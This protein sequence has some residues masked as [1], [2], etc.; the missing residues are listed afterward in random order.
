MANDISGLDGYLYW[1]KTPTDAPGAFSL[2]L[3]QTPTLDPFPVGQLTQATDYRGQ[4][5]VSAVDKAGNATAKVAFN[6]IEAQTLNPNPETTPMPAERVARI[7]AIVAKCL[8]AG[9][10]PGITLGIVSPYGYLIKSYGDGSTSKEKYFRMASQSKMMTARAVLR[11]IE[12]GLLSFE[13]TLEQ[14]IPGVPNGEM[15]TVEHML[16]MTSGIFDHQL[17]ASLGLNFTLN[18]TMAMSVDQMIDYIKTGAPMFVPGEGYYY[19][20]GNYFLLGRILEVLDPDQRSADQI[21]TEDVLIPV[22]MSNTYWQV[23]TGVPRSPYDIMYDNDPISST[24]IGL[25]WGLTL[26]LFGPAPVV[27]RDVSAQNPNFVWAAGAN[28]SL[29]TDMI[30][31]G[32]ELLD[33]TLLSTEMNELLTTHFNEHPTPPWGLQKQGPPRYK[34]GY[35]LYRIEEWIGHGGSWLGADSGTMVHPDTGTIITVFNNFQ[36]PTAPAMTT[37]FF[38]IATDLLPGSTAMAPTVVRPESGSIGYSGGTPNVNVVSTGT[39]IPTPGTITFTGGQPTIV[40]PV[41]PAAGSIGF[42]GG[43]PNVNVVPTFE[44]V[45][46]FNQN[47]TDEPIPAGATVLRILK[48]RG[49]G[50]NGSA[51]TAVYNSTGG[52]GGGSGAVVNEITIPVADLDASVYSTKWG[53]NGGDS[54]LICGGKRLTAKGGKPGTLTT[55]YNA[56]VAGGLGGL[57]EAVG[58]S[59]ATG[60]NGKKGGDSHMN[61]GGPGVSGAG[62]DVGGSGAGGRGSWGGIS[63]GVQPGGSS[64]TVTGTTGAG[65]DAAGDGAGAGGGEGEAGGDWGAGGGGGYSYGNVGGGAGGAGAPGLIHLRWE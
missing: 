36:W 23:D 54:E 58:V 64:L 20:N 3:N 33:G 4:Y 22:G 27:K 10:G 43:T 16:T 29:I 9:A 52:S 48:I 5:A 62:V 1:K 17:A 26:G 53:V 15:I 41:V 31:W 47:L 30:K 60:A 38:E 55:A 35:G 28:I 39:V 13:D 49:S 34:Y 19:T 24:I 56:T 57:W 65:G 12:L 51:G 21:I 2:Q 14:F 40:A 8:A 50:G 59:G 11:F 18:P 63:G 42:T 46:V 44:P 7:D 45:E 37:L 6:N 25:F 32:Q 61:G